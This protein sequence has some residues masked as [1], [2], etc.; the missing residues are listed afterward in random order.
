MI[1]LALVVC[2]LTV[3]A[4][5]V[6]VGAQA[7]PEA[8]S[9]IYLPLLKGPAG[10]Q[11]PDEQAVAA[12]VISLI[13]AERARAGCGPLAADPRLTAA[14]QGHSEDMAAN[15]FFDHRGS[16]GTT[17]SDRVTAAGYTWRRVGENIAAGYQ[18]A[19]AVVAGW[20]E[21]PD[22]RANILNCAYAHTGVGYVYDPGDGT[23][24]DGDGPYF[25]YWTQVFAAPR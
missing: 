23:L 17:V 3:S 20:M 24:D 10:I 25:R 8:T 6:E 18:G 15:D 7:T 21:S 5:T 13:N 1:V 9:R 16:A 11:T 12:Q 22:H 2:L 19:A 4:R 14:A